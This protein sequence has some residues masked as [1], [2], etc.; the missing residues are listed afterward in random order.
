MSAPYPRRRRRTTTLAILFFV[1]ALMALYAACNTA[2]SQ[3]RPQVIPVLLIVDDEDRT[4]VKRSSMVAK[5]VFS[6]LAHHMNRIGL[7]PIDED[8]V[9]ARLG[10]QLQD[11]QARNELRNFIRF[12]RVSG[13]F[14]DA[15]AIALLQLRI[16]MR[17]SKSGS[18]LSVRIVGELRDFASYRLIDDF[19]M[20]PREYR[21]ASR[22]DA[23]CVSELLNN[24]AHDIAAGISGLLAR[25][26]A[27][28]RDGSASRDYTVTFRDFDR[29]EVLSIVG[30]MAAEFPGYKNHR[31]IDTAP[32]MRRYVYG[33]S[34][35]LAKLEE[36]LTILLDDMSLARDKEVLIQVKVDEI[37][38]LRIVPR[39][40]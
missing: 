31:L 5:T 26:L 32:D 38:I 30:V 19:Q 25:K 22:C 12:V 29:R 33:S 15:S 3:G 8:T 35:N 20:P 10:L 7:Q 9:A 24:R 37:E 28:Y 16:F 4:S 14:A 13:K 2:M 40:R 39:N 11:R 18:V 36:W 6:A 34:A 27:R 1:P 23:R 17:S 21:A